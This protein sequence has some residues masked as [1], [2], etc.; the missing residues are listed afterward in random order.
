[1]MKNRR[2]RVFIG[3]HEIAGFYRNLHE[4]FVKAGCPTRLVTLSRHPFGYEELPRD[5]IGHLLRWWLRKALNV[6]GETWSKFTPHWLRWGIGQTMIL[7]AALT[8]EVFIFSCGVTFADA[9]GTERIFWLKRLR[10]KAVVIFHGSD[11]RAPWCD[12][13]GYHRDG[14]RVKGPELLALIQTRKAKVQCA[15]AIADVV[16]D[17]PM[18]G[19]FHPKPFLNRLLFGTPTPATPDLPAKAATASQAVRILHCPS[20]SGIKGTAEIRRVIQRLQQ[21]GWPLDYVELSGVTNQ[22]VLDELGHC[23]FVIDQLFSD[24][25]MAGFAREAAMFGKA[26]LVGGYAW[27]ELKRYLPQEDWPPTLLCHPDRLEP[28]L[29]NLLQKGREKWQALGKLAERYVH[30]HWAPEACAERLLLALN[31]PHEPKA[32]VDPQTC[33]YLWGCGLHALESLELAQT[34]MRLAGPEAFCLE[35][36]PELLA[37]HI[38]L[39]SLHLMSDQKTL[40]PILAEMDEQLWSVARTL[41][42]R[43][44]ELEKQS[45]EA[46][47]VISEQTALIEQL[48]DHS[49]VNAELD[50]LQRMIQRR[51]ARIAK[52]TAKVEKLSKK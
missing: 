50:N 3:L 5:W 21:E 33:R 37:K 42:E 31:A 43:N 41:V 15:H 44:V 9:L 26:A 12:R 14:H 10:R 2:P 1:M 13:T 23:D 7:L 22:Q 27:E 20:D 34:L 25:P 45:V 19:H 4:G 49:I 29:R 35:D 52:L 36:K 30:T 40:P 38:E 39:G 18:S 24:I 17:W 8:H 6:E 47:K 46:A 32:W 51:D 48:N 11:S 16:M 28:A